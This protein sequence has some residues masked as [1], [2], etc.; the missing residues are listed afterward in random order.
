GPADQPPPAG[1]TPCGRLN[2][3]LAQQRGAL[4]RISRDRRFLQN[5]AQTTVWL[6]RGRTQRLD[7]GFTA[8]EAWRDEQLA[9]EELARHKLDRKIVREEQWL[10]YGHT[11]RRKR[12][13]RR[14]ADLQ[15]LREVRNT[16]CRAAGMATMAASQAELSGRMVAEAEGV[17]K[18]FDGRRIVAGFSHRLQRGD[19]LG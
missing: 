4:I 6:D 5:L 1:G 9:Q 19:R 7:A 15:T 11:A 17:A 16:Y 13:V 8:F 3:R 10:R 12:N 2:T 18:A 14:M